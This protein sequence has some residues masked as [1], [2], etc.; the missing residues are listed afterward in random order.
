MAQA[1]NIYIKPYPLTNLKVMER[2]SSAYITAD[3]SNQRYEA[4]VSIGRQVTI[5]AD[6]YWS[7]TVTTV[8]RETYT[9]IP[10]E[11]IG[12]LSNG[13]N[14]YIIE[15]EEARNIMQ[16]KSNMSTSLV[17]DL[18]STTK[19]PNTK[20]VYDALLGKENTSNRV[21]SLS[22]SSTDAQYPS[23][24]CV[25]DLIGDIETLINAL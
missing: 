21:F 1:G 19:Y 12:K 3:A 4:A 10:Y 8:D 9:L 20:I 24:K 16:L 15:D 23:A 7:Q 13:T 17:A 14:T 11:Y 5:S 22:S 18:A 25:Y 2:T 6:G